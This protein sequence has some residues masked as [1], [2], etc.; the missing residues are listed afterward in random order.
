LRLGT[1]DFPFSLVTGGKVA[2]WSEIDGHDAEGIYI[3]NGTELVKVVRTG[4]LLDGAE[5]SRLRFSYHGDSSRKGFN[6]NGQVAFIA[7]FTDGTQGVYLY[8][9]DLHIG[10]V[11]DESDL[12]RWDWP[13][14]IPPEEV[15]EVFIDPAKDV[16]VRISEKELKVKIL[17]LGGGKGTAT[18]TMK[19]GRVSTTA[20]VKIASNG[21]LEGTGTIKG[22]VE[23][24]GKIRPDRIEVDGN[25]YNKR[26]IQGRAEQDQVNV[27]GDLSNEGEIEG[28]LEVGCTFENLN[29]GRVQLDKGDVM[30]FSSTENSNSGLISVDHGKLRFKH[31]LD[32]TTRGRI[33]ASHAKLLFKDGL[34][35]SGQLSNYGSKVSGDIVNKSTG[36]LSSRSDAVYDGSLHNFGTLYTDD[37]SR[38]IFQGRLAGMGPLAGRGAVVM[39]G[40]FE[41]D[42]RQGIS[43]EG[44]LVLGHKCATTLSLHEQISSACVQVR[45]LLELGGRL[46]VVVPK[47]FKCSADD[48]FMLFQADKIRGKFDEIV[49]PRAENF[50][51]KVLCGRYRYSLLVSVI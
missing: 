9:P 16:N 37:N 45:S 47:G 49:L 36:K 35:N 17:T 5:V 41:P 1:Q 8:T 33:V 34:N 43:I 11:R 12:S 23:N 39:K 2:F 31:R 48:V 6:A 7:V 21:V 20:G 24:K 38:S 32:N 26:K 3:G 15:H 27:S 14:D 40:A 10:D 25:L 4:D 30:N 51:F 18:L 22:D 29:A 19:D 28:S 13:L 44:N 42:T 50:K 46:K